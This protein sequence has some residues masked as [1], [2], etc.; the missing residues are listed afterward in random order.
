MSEITEITRRAIADIFAI[1][2]ISWAGR[3]NDDEFLARLYDLTSLPSTDGRFSNAAGDIFQHCVRNN[4]WSPD[5]VF[6]DRRFNVLHETDERFLRF[7]CETV[8]PV[9]RTDGNEAKTLVEAFNKELAGDG[10]QIVEVKQISSRPV[11]IATALRGDRSVR[12]I[13]DLEAG[14]ANQFALAKALASG[15]QRLMQKAGLEAEIARLER[16][17]AAHFDDRHAVRRAIRDAENEIAWAE[18]RLANTEIDLGQRE[19]AHPFAMTVGRRSFR[20]EDA[21]GAALLEAIRGLLHARRTGEHGIAKLSGFEISF[22]GERRFGGKF[23]YTVSIERHRRRQETGINLGYNA[24]SAIACLQGKL[25]G[26][27]NEI[28]EAR[29]TAKREQERLAQYLAQPQ[30]EFP[31]EAELAAK[32]AELDEIEASLAATTRPAN[33]ELDE[34]A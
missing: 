20:D 14:Q 3:F 1:G 22:D 23:S 9:V 12:R 5:W 7:L 27:E 6:Y 17:R 30:G 8:H 21:A 2:N 31:L 24:V 18:S 16:L 29:M 33:A 25:D 4:D 11:F 32:Q 28:A 10:W 13:E 34:A 19:A 26:F 15:D